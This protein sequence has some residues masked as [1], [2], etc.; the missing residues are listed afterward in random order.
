MMSTCLVMS[1][2][3]CD[4]DSS[5]EPETPTN[6]W[7]P[8][9]ENVNGTLDD[10]QGMR[11]LTLWGTNYEQGYAH[12][13]LLG[14]EII[15]ALDL[16]F[17]D[18]NLVDIFEDVTLPNI[19]KFTIPDEY[20]NEIRG[21][22][23]GIQ[24]RAGGAVY[25][26]SLD[27]YIDLNDAIGVTIFN[28]VAH[29]P[30]C[31][32][33]SAWGDLT[34]DGSTLTGRNNDSPDN[35]HYTG[36]KIIIIRK[37]NPNSSALPLISV[38][39]PGDTHC[40]TAMN[41]EGVTL[42]CQAI[43]VFDQTTETEGFCPDGFIYRKM[44]ESAH[45]A[46]VVADVSIVLQNL[47][48]SGAEAVF[49]SWPNANDGPCAAVFEIDGNLNNGHGFS[50]RQPKVGESYLIQTN[51]FWLRSMPTTCWRYNHADAALSGITA[52]NN[53]PLTVDGTW[54]LLGEVAPTEA[55]YIVVHA[56]VFEP[57]RM[58][59][60]VAFGEPGTHAPECQKIML[61]VAQLLE[62]TINKVPEVH[63]VFLISTQKNEGDEHMSMQG[64]GKK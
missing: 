11:V 39:D 57:N 37:P 21:M 55:G 34:E 42:A 27:R 8:V 51:N 63:D 28:D 31:T 17:T 6:N 22:A 24:A 36:R 56:E 3:A 61:D 60:H 26:S 44:I 12:G 62:S 43:D 38:Q 9:T 7:L 1:L 18:L 13:Y 4:K 10:I 40:S 25:S 23:Q 46:S 29:I 58:R 20:M 53:A 35:V 54:D 30:G 2:I 64:R 59:M 47:Y 52:G 16:L 15:E 14:Q 33:F 19:D 5:T 32:S 48:M 41:S 45:A 49:M 50:V